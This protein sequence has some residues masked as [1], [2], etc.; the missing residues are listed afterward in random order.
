MINGEPDLEVCA[1]AGTHQIAIEQIILRRP[2]MATVDLS[3][4]ESD[5]LDL[6][7]EIRE[8]F[9]ALPVLVISMHD[10]NIYA[11]RAFRA[12]A[13]GYISKQQLDETLLAAIRC[14]LAGGQ[15]MSPVMGIRFAQKYLSGESRANESPVA[16][17]SDRELQVFRLI[18]EGK[19]TRQI[20]ERFKLSIKTIETYR[21]HLKAKLTLH[22][23]AD[24]ARCATRWVETG[25][26]A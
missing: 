11:E 13:R 25:K 12:G 22:S 9:P 6:I 24:L 18:G 1:E 7:K 8:R 5:G 4:G 20:A 15:Y 2:D 26:Y 21:E 16:G 23:G 14:V 19:T 10:E 3:L 17:L